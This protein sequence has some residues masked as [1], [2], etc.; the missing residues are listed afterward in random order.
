MLSALDVGPL[1]TADDVTES[2]IVPVCGK[3]KHSLTQGTLQS[4][5]KPTA[6]TIGILHVIYANTF[7]VK[8]ATNKL[9]L[10]ETHQNHS[11]A[12]YYLP[13]PPP[14]YLKVADYSHSL[15]FLQQYNSSTSP[16]EEIEM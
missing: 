11:F 10:L 8:T 16:K 14:I 5:R 6:F 2:A 7:T 1:K 12:S 4:L 3:K 13:A 15:V 9:S